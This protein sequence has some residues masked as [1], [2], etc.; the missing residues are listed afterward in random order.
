MATRRSSTEKDYVAIAKKRVTRPAD[1][2]PKPKL[3]IYGRNKKGKTTFGLSAGTE[4]TLVLD[5][6]KGTDT[7]REK[8]PYRWPLN[9]WADMQEAWGALRTGELS[10]STFGGESD[11]PFQWVVVDGLTKINNMA[12]RYIMSQ[13]ELK[14]L[15]RKPGMVD[16]R[17]YNKSGELM[18]SM[19]QNFQN[20]NM[21][22]VFTAQ[23]RMMS[24]DS[25]D[26]DEDDETTYFVPDLP[27]GVRGAVNS[28]VD[29]IAR[30]YVVRIEDPNDPEK[31]KPQRRLQIG[32]HERYDTGYRSDFVLPDMIKN[33]TLPKLVKLMYT[34]SVK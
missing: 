12:L 14:D 2:S 18:K 3:L 13:A 4:V 17:D 7:M 10:P 19:L 23:E 16:R 27:A 9:E 15:D 28:I 8:N 22:V 32:V 24:M 31:M 25:G 11:K 20:L 1:G 5:P 26:S 33:P 6:E 30:V 21:G 29:V 34:G